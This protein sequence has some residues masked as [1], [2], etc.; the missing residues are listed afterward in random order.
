M[1]RYRR[2]LNFAVEYEKLAEH[3]LDP[4]MREQWLL[5]A[6]EFRAMAKER[7]EELGTRGAN[8]AVVT[9]PDPKSH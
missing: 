9:S 5:L 7:L 4:A 1:E 2:F 8:R 6:K 3:A